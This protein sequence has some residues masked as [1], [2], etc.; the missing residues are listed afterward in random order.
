M[1]KEPGGLQS[2]GSQSQAGLGT[3]PPTPFLCSHWFVIL[4]PFPHL[5]FLFVSQ[6]YIFSTNILLFLSNTFSLEFGSSKAKVP[7]LKQSHHLSWSVVIHLHVKQ[8]HSNHPFNVLS[9]YYSQRLWVF[10]FE[11][12][13]THKGILSTLTLQVSFKPQFY[14]F[15]SS[16]LQP[17]DSKILECSGRI[18]WRWGV[19]L[20][21]HSCYL[22]ICFRNTTTLVTLK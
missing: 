15:Q 18:L 20:V 7:A 8:N 22:F 11:H 4:Q 19:V 2:V 13:S 9:F 1:D 17:L 14:L 3:K 12:H 21:C 5:L 6:T 16:W 10:V